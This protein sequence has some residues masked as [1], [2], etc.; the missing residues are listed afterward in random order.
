MRIPRARE[1]RYARTCLCKWRIKKPFITRARAG[2][3]KKAAGCGEGAR[4]GGRRR[5]RRWWR[6]GGRLIILSRT[7]SCQPGAAFRSGGHAHARARPR[8]HAAL[9]RCEC[10]HARAAACTYDGCRF[11]CARS[12]AHACHAVQG[13]CRAMR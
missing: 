2:A 9:Q 7:I 5:R 8:T 12:R 4:G 11:R 6:A 10:A 13:S 1:F 3:A